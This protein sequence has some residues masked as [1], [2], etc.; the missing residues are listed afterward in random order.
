VYVD[1]PLEQARKTMIDSGAPE[2][3]VD[4]QMEQ[5]QV[6]LK[7]YQSAVTPVISEIAKREPV[8]F[9]QFAKEHAAY[10]R[11]EPAAVSHGN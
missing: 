2:W 7:G 4:G 5:Y 9:D 10:F 8:S 1:V 3:F 6:R 11:G